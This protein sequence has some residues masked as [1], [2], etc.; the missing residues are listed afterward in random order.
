MILR[1]T[2]SRTTSA[3]TRTD[4]CGQEASISELDSMKLLRRTW[5][6]QLPSLDF[7][8]DELCSMVYVRMLIEGNFQG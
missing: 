6:R 4:V 7:G 2:A 3:R 5:P 8:D 1:P